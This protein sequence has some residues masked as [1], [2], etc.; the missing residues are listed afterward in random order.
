M[1]LNVRLTWLWA[2]I[3]GLSTVGAGLVAFVFPQTLLRPVIIMWFLFFCPG[4]TIVRFFRLTEAAIV[5]TLALALSF[6]I[7]ALVASVLLYGGWWSPERILTILLIFCFCGA[8][9]QCF[10]L[11]ST[12][13]VPTKGTDGGRPAAL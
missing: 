4:M 3:I 7:D 8:I 10:T 2:A 13:M 1:I 5:W 6:A 9:V 11:R 12:P